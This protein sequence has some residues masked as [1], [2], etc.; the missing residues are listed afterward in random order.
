MQRV[1]IVL[2]QFFSLGY[3]LAYRRGGFAGQNEKFN[4]PASEGYV[5]V[6]FTIKVKLTSANSKGE[7]LNYSSFII[8]M[9]PIIYV[10][11]FFFVN[12]INDRISYNQ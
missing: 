11:V 6:A 12:E 10:L 3:S 9:F 1:Y 8:S 7:N 5:F 4:P 2:S